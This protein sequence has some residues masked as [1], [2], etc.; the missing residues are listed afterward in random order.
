MA[1]GDKLVTLD[2]LKA[3]HDHV[4]GKVSDLRSI[5]KAYTHETENMLDL[6]ATP[7][8]IEYVTKELGENTITVTT[9]AARKYANIGLCKIDVTNINSIFVNP[10]TSEG[11]GQA[12][13]RV[14]VYK[15][16]GTSAW[17]GVVDPSTGTAFDVSNSTYV[18]VVIALY[19]HYSADN[20]SVGE[21]I[22]YS[23][24]MVTEGSVAKE[25]TPHLTAVDV[26]ARNQSE[27]AYNNLKTE[28][29]QNAG[30]NYLN[31]QALASGSATMPVSIMRLGDLSSVG[32]PIYNTIYRA[33][34]VPIL[35]LPFNALIT[36]PSAFYMRICY[37]TD[38]E[39]TGRED[40]EWN[41]S[42]EI[43]AG[44]EFRIMIRNVPETPPPPAVSDVDTFA[45]AITVTNQSYIPGTGTQIYT[46]EQIKLETDF[47]KQNRCSITEW[48][49]FVNATGLRLYD[50]QS[51]AAFGGYM[52]V[53]V[54]AGGG[55]VLD[56][57][58]K[59]IISQFTTAYTAD[60]H[61]NSAQFSDIYYAEGDE[62]PLLFVSRCNGNAPEFGDEN[63]DTCL[64]YR[65]TKSGTQFTFTLV[66]TILWDHTTYGL[67]WSVDSGARMLY[68]CSL[69]N[70]R[71]TVTENNPLVFTA[72]DMPTKTQILSGDT[73]TLTD[74]DVRIHFEADHATMQGSTAANGVLYV[75]VVDETQ[76][77]VRQ[78]ILAFDA[79]R[80]RVTAKVK[81]L[82]NLECEG[83]TIADGIMYVSQ[84]RNASSG[85]D[86]PLKI[87]AIEFA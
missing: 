70:G 56:M 36:C 65:V 32:E 15:S 57:A 72:F 44:Q 19:A 50:N 84:R 71:Y 4:N 6:Y 26:V 1:T 58:T 76:S 8:Y 39:Y 61:Q 80:Q 66:N 14:R 38:G 11:T 25:Y 35:S 37:Y 42:I 31:D 40:P 60:D 75:A 62:F 83:V 85:D 16:D 73:I 54:D 28:V 48:K 41:R 43:P 63:L 46:G 52:F 27:S 45:A 78:H 9:T 81:L 17:L 10:Y 33:I 30:V 34:T 53:F 79:V 20:P 77:G 49:D 55:I 64:V 69:Q 21:Y 67:D 74:N 87:Y 24:L 5:F 82:N 3:A 51:I 13:V 23:G 68:T 47:N 86:N 12:T 18:S 7:Q 2:G 29:D 22:T 59:E